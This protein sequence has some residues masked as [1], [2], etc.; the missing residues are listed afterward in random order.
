MEADAGVPGIA[1]RLSHDLDSDPAVVRYDH[2]GNSTDSRVGR[3]RPS[4]AA[5]SATEHGLPTTASAPNGM[6][7]DAIRDGSSPVT[8]TMG[9]FGRSVC[10]SRKS[11][12]ASSG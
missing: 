1:H 4:S 7:R 8:T 3:Y 6:T 5:T 10:S 2:H 11:R 12:R 9:V